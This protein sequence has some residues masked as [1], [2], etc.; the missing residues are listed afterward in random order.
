[1]FINSKH[2]LIITQREHAKL[3]GNIALN[4]GNNDFDKP[5]IPF[6][7]FVE[8][9]AF[10]QN[11]SDCFDTY[12]AAA[13]NYDE[14]PNVLAKDFYAKL[15]SK[16]ASLI[17]MYHQ[18]RLATRISKKID[19]DTLVELA[20]EFKK[21]IDKQLITSEFI[22]QDFLWADKIANMCDRLAFDFSNG[23]SIEEIFEI[24]SEVKSTDKTVIKFKFDGTEISLDKWPFC[25][26]KLRFNVIGFERDKY[27]Q[28]LIPHLIQFE[29]S[30]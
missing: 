2:N 22:E 29:L 13:G 19:S 30:L 24:Y 25:S 7:D 12:Q 3:A 20:D 6:H 18:Y 17:N 16:V 9:I 10:H 28:V 1:M 14:L 15:N 8:G 5:K 4:W 26:D 23:K 11:G 21:E 27:P